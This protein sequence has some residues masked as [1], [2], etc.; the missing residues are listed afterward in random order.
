MAALK[1]R[2]ALKERRCAVSL[3]GFRKSFC[4]DLCQFCSVCSGGVHSAVAAS[5]PERTPRWP[6]LPTKASTFCLQRMEK[7]K[8]L[9]QILVINPVL[10]LLGGQMLKESD[11]IFSGPSRQSICQP[12][13]H[14]CCFTVCLTGYIATLECAV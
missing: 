2:H 14:F 13:C 12:I 7:S 9:L 1:S 5:E 10:C 11:G 8:A 3:Q 6:E 4:L